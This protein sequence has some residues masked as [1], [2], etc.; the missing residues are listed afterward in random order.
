MWRQNADSRTYL[1][2]HIIPPSVRDGENILVNLHLNIYRMR[3][4][5]PINRNGL[6]GEIQRSLRVW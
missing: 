2:K 4:N 6:P 1:W 3:K 5:C